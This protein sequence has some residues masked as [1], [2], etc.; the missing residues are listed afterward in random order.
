MLANYLIGLRE[1]LE[2]SLVISILIAYLVKT[3]NRSSLPA[4][5][6]GVGVALGVSLVFGA[7][8][9]FTSQSMSFKA[10]ETF[11]GVMSIIAVVFVTWMIFWMRRTAR[12]LAGELRGKLDAAI[13]IGGVAVAVT[14]FIA[15][16][17]EGLETSLFIWAAVQSTGNGT[18][19]VVGAVVG[20]LTAVV[21]GY[22][23]YRGALRINLS[24]F[25]TWTGAA[26]IIIAAGVL[27][28]AVHDLQE[29]EILPGLNNYAFDVSEQIPPSSWYGSLIKGVFNIS[30]AP[31][32]LETIVWFA[33]IIAVT[34][35]FFRKPKAP[36]ALQV[37]SAAQ[38][39]PT[40]ER[41]SVV[42]SQIA[43]SRQ[44]LASGASKASPPAT[45][46][47]YRKGTYSNE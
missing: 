42:P 46:S 38:T 36:L 28:Y 7:G 31:S 25:F 47:H 19:P 11:G 37:K 43:P 2:A 26:L 8:L 41:S 18:S 6:W 27:A 17:R 1:G 22:L 16:A 10:Q 20:L 30:A 44:P 45:A 15:V 40:A 34:Y 24:K 39:G 5:W 14:A 29:A 12:N 21:L 35:L 13:R 3:G 32:I 33:Y 4:L 9:T 23:F